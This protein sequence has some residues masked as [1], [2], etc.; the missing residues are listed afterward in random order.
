MVS[1]NPCAITFLTNTTIGTHSSDLFISKTDILYVAGE[2]LVSVDIASG[3]SHF[4]LRNVSDHLLYSDS[5]FATS[6]GDVYFH[7]KHIENIGEDYSS[8]STLASQT[9]SSTKSEC[10]PC[11]SCD[12]FSFSWCIGWHCKC[13][14]RGKCSEECNSGTD[15]S[16]NNQ[17]SGNNVSSQNYNFGTIHKWSVNTTNISVNITINGSCADIFS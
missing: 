3:K 15:N 10:R 14:L 13:D 4:L 2:T 9:Q 6:D 1:W 7:S 8:T 17:N 16:D 5:V 12:W 11:W